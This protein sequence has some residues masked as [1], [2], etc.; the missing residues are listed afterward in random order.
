MSRVGRSTTATERIA[1][2]AH[3][4]PR[5]STS[6]ALRSHQRCP[7][8]LAKSRCLSC[9]QEARFIHPCRLTRSRAPAFA[10]YVAGCLQAAQPSCVPGVPGFRELAGAEL[11]NSRWLHICRA[12][13]SLAE[14][15]SLAG[16]AAR[17]RARAKSPSR[18]A[19]LLLRPSRAPRRPTG[20]CG[21][22]TT[23]SAELAD[24]AILERGD[25]AAIARCGCCC[26]CCRRRRCRCCC[27]CCGCCSCSCCSCCCGCG[28]GGCSAAPLLLSL[29][30]APAAALAA[31]SCCAAAA[32][33]EVLLWLH[34]QHSSAC[35]GAQTLARRGVV[36]LPVASPL[37]SP[38]L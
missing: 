7:L 3:A 23:S 1:C 15:R 26:C 13:A 28:C 6:P 30:P 27:D 14:A 33:A 35:A 4:S 8:T 20:P 24:Q 22:A 18:G 36:A 34:L 19:G 38:R 5:L 21:G 25:R 12:R 9:S 29:Q 31:C 11:G 10:C 16:D 17:A 32:V 2:R 37:A